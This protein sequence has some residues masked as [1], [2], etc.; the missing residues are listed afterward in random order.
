MVNSNKVIKEEEEEE[1]ME[2]EDS[3]M[4]DSVI[5]EDETDSFIQE[6]RDSFVQPGS[7]SRFALR[8]R[9]RRIVSKGCDEESEVKS[10]EIDGGDSISVCSLD[11]EQDQPESKKKR[12]LP[13]ISS[14]SS[15]LSLSKPIGK[16]SW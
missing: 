3:I 6:E 7:K 16:K 4:E 8:K 15:M 1:N 5:E 2:T 12:N 10:D 14:L 11:L 9:K 13:R